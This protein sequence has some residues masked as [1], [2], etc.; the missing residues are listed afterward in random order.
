MD[1]VDKAKNFVA[2]KVANMPKPEAAI[3]DVDLKGFGLEGITLLAKVSVS[4]PYAVPIPIGEIA[5]TVK[6]AERGIAS[7]SIPDPGSLK[8]NDKTMLD[9]TVKVPHS[10]V[11]SLIRDIGG[12][13]DIDYLLELGLIIDLPVIG[14][15]T[16]PMS[17][18]GEMKLPT[19]SD[20][21]KGKSTAEEGKSTEQE[22]KLT[23]EEGN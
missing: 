16:I 4:N 3:T 7:G 23:A 8:A 14:N 13:W 1:L 21:F 10:A 12:D 9:V 17:Y 19:F 20:F 18:K 5:Y 2:E 6:S 22:G 15:I 11:V